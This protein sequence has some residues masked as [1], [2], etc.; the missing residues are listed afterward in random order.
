MSASLRSR[1]PLL[2]FLLV[3][4]TWSFG[5]FGHYG[6]T[7]DE[8]GVYVRGMALGHSFSHEDTQI[9]FKHAPDDGL[10]IY[11]HFYP[12]V[13]SLLN[14]S[15]DIDVYHWLNTLFALTAFI[16]LFELLLVRVQKPW[17]ALLGPV[18]LA[19]TPRFLGDIPANPKDMP[20]AVFYLLALGLIYFFHQRS[21]AGLLAQALLLG[22]AFGL[23][24]SSRILGL[25]LFPVYVLFDLH[26]LCRDPKQGWKE[27][28]VHLRDMI[29]LLTS[30]F[31]VSS[32]FLIAT[33][34]YLGSNFFLHFKEALDIS[35]DFFWKNPVLFFG[36]EI[37]ADHL[38]WTYLPVW[39]LLTT[40]LFILFFCATSFFFIPK[41]MKD[42]LYILMGV[43]V[44]V[45]GAFYL[46]FK[47]VLYD[48][49]R[50]FLFLLPLL[51]AIAALS[52]A[53]WF[54][55]AK[56]NGWFKGLLFL[57][58]LNMALVGIHLVRLHPYEYVYFNELTGGLKGSFGKFDNDYWG[59]SFKEAVEW[60][61]KNEITDPR[62]TYKVTGSGNRYQ[63][64]YYFTPNM[65]WVDDLKD[66]DYYVSYGRDH[67]QD[68][69][70]PLQLV[71]LVERERVPLNYIYKLK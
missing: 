33:W 16:L 61:E 7:F 42:P 70:N 40:P 65:V 66:A 71:H 17:L 41:M 8:S 67:K 60:L 21:R 6:M 10:V 63:I 26:F 3:Y 69:A 30:V 52:A 1:F 5:T 38:P 39:F 24:E 46:L 35:S 51:A 23:A 45:N 19:L 54:Q 18:F 56:R 2:L 55:S 47:P 58:V 49:L 68:L 43:A 29:L 12:Y 50:H 44:T 64:L 9:L 34:P 59:S 22:L 15:A 25:T 20:F 53:H 13:L 27:W 62:H 32:F 37:P 14:P 57:L 31:I 4:L 48:G 36:Q 28:K 11:D